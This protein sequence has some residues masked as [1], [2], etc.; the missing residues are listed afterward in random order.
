MPKRSAIKPK[1]SPL[2]EIRHDVHHQRRKLHNSKED[3]GAEDA[4]DAEVRRTTVKGNAHHLSLKVILLTNST[5]ATAL[6][7]QS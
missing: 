4:I 5:S 2:H 3:E 6:S 7:P 1:G